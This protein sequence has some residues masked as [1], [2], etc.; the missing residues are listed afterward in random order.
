MSTSESREADI[1]FGGLKEAG[2]GREHGV[3]VVQS[4]MEL[5]VLNVPAPAV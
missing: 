4:Y 5:Q 2:L 3:T 1:P